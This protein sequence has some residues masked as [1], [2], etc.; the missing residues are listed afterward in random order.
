MK[1]TTKTRFQIDSA[2]EYTNFIK[3]FISF[4]F[5][6]RFKFEIK[7][8]Q[9]RIYIGACLHFKYLIKSDSRTK[10]NKFS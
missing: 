2:I 10:N 1:T 9:K 7:T 6:K 4:H 8:Q 3:G 5:A